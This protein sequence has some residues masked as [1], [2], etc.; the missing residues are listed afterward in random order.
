MCKFLVVSLLTFPVFAQ[1]GV[2]DGSI[3]GTIHD[4][5]DAAVSGASVNAKNLETGFER[6]AVSNQVGEFE[7]PLLLPGRYEVSIS[8]SGFAPFRQT[9]IVVQLA[10]ASSLDVKLQVAS[11]QESVTVQADASILTVSSTDVSGDMNSLAMEDMPLTTQY[12]QPGAVCSRLQRPAR[13]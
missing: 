5:S 1:T 3:R 8:V 6:S 4:S 10:K 9:G 2:A 7:V 12:L 13:R 11:A